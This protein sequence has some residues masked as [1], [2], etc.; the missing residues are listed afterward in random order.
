MGQNRSILLIYKVGGDVLV[1]GIKFFVR[2]FYF[3]FIC[4]ILNLN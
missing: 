2:R 1:I 4:D 3:F